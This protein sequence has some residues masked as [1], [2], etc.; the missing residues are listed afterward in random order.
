MQLSSIRFRREE[1]TCG[2]R[3]L[4]AIPNVYL[5]LVSDQMREKSRPR[6]S[7]LVLVATHSMHFRAPNGQ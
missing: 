3:V 2:C 6:N 7:A 4:T 1:K 5:R